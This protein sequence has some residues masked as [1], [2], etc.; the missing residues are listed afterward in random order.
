MDDRPAFLRVLAVIPWV[1]GALIFVAVFLWLS[2]SL[3]TPS[4]GEEGTW[5]SV[6]PDAPP[7]P[8]APDDPAP[9]VHPCGE[10]PLLAARASRGALTEEERA[11]LDAAFGATLEPDRREGLSS[12]LLAD[13]WARDDLEEWELRANVHLADVDPGDPEVAWRY[14]LLLG[15]LGEDR[16]REAW[17][18]SD[19][20][21]D[22]VQRQVGPEWELRVADLL[23]VRTE[24][25]FAL[26]ETAPADEADRAR[27]AAWRAASAW[28]H[29][30]VEAEEDVETVRALCLDAAATDAQR[31]DCR[32]AG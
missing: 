1:G 7:L 25:A 14:A 20:A 9:P 12:L 18:W 23:A 8:E 31:A 26:W 21:I 27:E 13:A 28:Y 24:A 32:P 16:A 11:C 6:R 5:F 2:G 19:Y 17:F 29:H 3:R 30:A 15:D 4:P 10:P 22:L